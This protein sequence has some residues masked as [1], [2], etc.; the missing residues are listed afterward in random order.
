M[1]FKHSRSTIGNSIIDR[2]QLC[3]SLNDLLAQTNITNETS[4][5]LIK[6]FWI[7]V[8]LLQV[9]ALYVKSTSLETIFFPVKEKNQDSYL[10]QVLLDT[11]CLK[12]C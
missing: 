1:L 10:N 7:K 6:K 5:L 8:K 12:L 3:A 11:K 2:Y 4:E 9:K